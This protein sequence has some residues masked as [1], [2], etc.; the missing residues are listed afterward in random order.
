MPI[1]IIL[2]MKKSIFNF[3]K[4]ISYYFFQHYFRA[5][6]LH[7][8]FIELLYLDILQQLMDNIVSVFALSLRPC[9]N[10]QVSCRRMFLSL[11]LS[12]Y[13][14]LSVQLGNKSNEKLWVR[15]FNDL[16]LPLYWLP[17]ATC[18]SPSHLYLCFSLYPLS[19]SFTRPACLSLINFENY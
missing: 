6:K 3:F 13:R 11:P 16:L 9:L 5:C 7:I 1:H 19:L 2:K 14:P 12:F 8:F 10:I 17:F 4:L 15:L 18:P